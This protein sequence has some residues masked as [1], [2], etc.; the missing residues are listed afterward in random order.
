MYK[1]YVLTNTCHNKTY[2]GITNNT[3]R[4]IRQHNSELVGGAKYTTANKGDG[5]WK[6]YGFIENLEKRLALSIE[7]RIKI[8]SRRF[9]GTPIERRVKAINKILE[10]YEELSFTI[11]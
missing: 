9:S 2:V 5:E 11:I 7:K 1:V 6:Y 8:H 4:R 3:V 10:D